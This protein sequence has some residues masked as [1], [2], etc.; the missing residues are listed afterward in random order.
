V[1]PSVRPEIHVV[2]GPAL[3]LLTAWCRHVCMCLHSICMLVLGRESSELHIVVQDTRS[4][5]K[6]TAQ[7]EVNL[8]NIR[9]STSKSLLLH[10]RREQASWSETDILLHDRLALT[11]ASQ[12]QR[13]SKRHTGH[14]L[15]RR[16][17]ASEVE[18]LQ[19]EVDRLAAG[20]LESRGVVESS[21]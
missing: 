12:G 3:T 13:A 11:L 5:T 18:A 10:G 1:N 8:I 4:S 15:L 21:G 6:Q 9:P 16:S 7:L 20:W 19:R 2:P 17:N 14:S